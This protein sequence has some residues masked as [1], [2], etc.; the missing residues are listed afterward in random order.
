M[1]LFIGLWGYKHVAKVYN[2][3]EI[4][5]FNSCFLYL[6]IRKKNIFAQGLFL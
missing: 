3:F 2:S 5:D 6:C 4:I 1:S